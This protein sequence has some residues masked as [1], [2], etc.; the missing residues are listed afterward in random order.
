MIRTVMLDHV[1]ITA[2][3]PAASIR[4]YSEVLGLERGPEWPGEVTMLMSG[5][6]TA[7]AIAWWAEGSPRAEQPA[8]TV[9]HFAF[10]VNRET[11]LR[12]RDELGVRGVDVDHESDH[13]IEQ[14]LYFRDPDGHLVELA[15][16]DIQGKPEKMPRM[17][18][19]RVS[20]A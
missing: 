4:F 6:S 11:Y 20:G 19:V 15:C 7:I 16:Y 17:P 10:R 14:S 9:D 8:I 3:D 2:R 1:T 13:G 12:A 5:A 18:G